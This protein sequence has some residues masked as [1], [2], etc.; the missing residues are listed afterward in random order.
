MQPSNDTSEQHYEVEPHSVEV[1]IRRFERISQA[2]DIYGF[3]VDAEEHELGD[4]NEP[5]NSKAALSELES[6]KLLDA[7]NAEMQSMKDIKAIRI[8][9]AII[10]FYDYKIWQMDVKTALL[11]GHLSEDQAYKSW[12]KRFDEEIKKVGFTQ[13]PDEP[14]VYLKASESSVEFLVLYVDDILI[15]G[16][17]VTMLQDI[18]SWLSDYI[19]DAEASMEAV[20]MRKFIDGLGNVMPANK[21]PMKML[22]NN[23]SAIAMANDPRRMRGAKGNITT[24]VK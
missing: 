15:M 18:K 1:P 8:L 23:A 21:R 14:C 22:C 3:H 6:N 9:L 7:I 4:L 24:F 13:N 2:P 20:W 16:N 17:N 19:V 10:A 5:P 12:N 11:N